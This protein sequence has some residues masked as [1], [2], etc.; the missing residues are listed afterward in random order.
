[1][2]LVPFKA[3]SRILRRH[4]NS[5]QSAAGRWVSALS[6]EPRAGGIALLHYE[7]FLRT[8]EPDMAM[9][10]VIF[11]DNE[12]NPSTSGEVV[13]GRVIEWASRRRAQR[14]MGA[15]NAVVVLAPFS[16][17]ETIKA[18]DRWTTAKT[19]EI[20]I[21]DKGPRIP[22]HEILARTWP[23][24]MQKFILGSKFTSKVLI[25]TYND[26]GIDL[27]GE[28]DSAKTT[29]NFMNITQ[30]VKN[31]MTFTISPLMTFSTR[32]DG[33]RGV[34]T[35]STHYGHTF[36]GR[37]GQVVLRE[38]PLSRQELAVQHAWSP[39]PTSPPRQKSTCSI[40]KKSSVHHTAPSYRRP[41]RRRMDATSTG[42]C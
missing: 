27:E 15:G 30:A 14:D 11:M 31:A 38:R 34:M 36:D 16:C 8:F 20:T 19:R 3:E 6:K 41:T 32:C 40:P 24:R 29:T 37:I 26:N 9:S 1:V 4:L 33:L 21:E 10:M 39:S 42:Q 35:G 7:E 18:F 22:I 25:C 17:S 5:I 28:E 2:H 13:F 12:V 23:A